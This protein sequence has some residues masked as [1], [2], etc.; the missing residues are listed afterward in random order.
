MRLGGAGRGRH[1]GPAAQPTAMAGRAAGRP[2]VVLVHGKGGHRWGA[3]QP[4]M[5]G[6]A[7]G[8]VR[9]KSGAWSAVL[10]AAD[11]CRYEFR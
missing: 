8:G 9:G 4:T 10:Q 5:A 11:T 1:G 6:S 7:G 2:N 3:A